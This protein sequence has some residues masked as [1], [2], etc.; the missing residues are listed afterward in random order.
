MPST[1]D[2]DLWGAFKIL[3][4]SPNGFGKTIAGASF[5]EAG[6]M[7]IADFDGRIQPI[8]K[9]YP[10][11]DIDY[12][13]YGVDD[14][15]SFLNWVEDIQRNPPKFKTIMI[16]SLTSL[17]MT[18][19]MFS[20]AVKG[21]K[22]K[23]GAQTGLVSTS[24][25]EVNTETVHIS[26][27]LEALKIVHENHK[28]NIIM[29]AHPITKTEIIPETQGGGS[30]KS[31]VLVAYGNKIGFIAPGYFNEI[32]RLGVKKTDMNG[33]LRRF[34]YTSQTGENDEV[35]AKSALPI[36]I[37]IDITNGLYRAL[38]SFKK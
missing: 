28:I 2:I 25:D 15:R 32:Y 3:L 20:L 26:K 7:H 13:S 1:K 17:S 9:V 30:K 19:V 4:V 10:N 38:V 24:W 27:L 22:A 18:H 29:T 12:K 21:G 33:N 8:K 14:Y 34:I 31:E 36:P 37:E 16:D 11:A 23:T 35:M 5:Y 6:P